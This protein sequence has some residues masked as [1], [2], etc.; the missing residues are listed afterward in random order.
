VHH[1]NLILF[2][3]EAAAEQAPSGFIGTLGLNWKLFLAQ[4]VNFAIVLFILWRW[5]FKPVVRAL[6]SRRQKI[7]NSVKQAEDIEKRVYEFEASQEERLKKAYAEAEEI[8]KKAASSAEQSRKETLE[9]ARAEAEKILSDMKSAIAA[10]KEQMLQEV[11]EE[12]AT[13]T[14]MATEKILRAKLDLRKDSEIV[15]EILQ[16]INK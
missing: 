4:L 16:S 14:V 11:R 12:L 1:I 6:E 8:L 13:L 9:V 5:V 7:E 15:R 2:A 10:E 3:T